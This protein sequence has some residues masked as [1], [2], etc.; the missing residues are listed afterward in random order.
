MLQNS[1]I[2][3]LN[4]VYRYCESKDNDLN[5][6]RTVIQ[7]LVTEVVRAEA[8]QVKG[9]K[10]SMYNYVSKNATRPVMECVY[11][12]N[13][14]KVASDGHI[15]VAIKEDYEPDFE[16]RKF[17]KDGE[18]VTDCRYPNWKSVIPRKDGWK[19]ATIDEQKF[20]EWIVER[21]AEHLAKVGKKSKWEPTWLVRINGTFFIMAEYFSLL[22][23][24]AK[25]IGT[26]VV[27]TSNDDKN[28]PCMVEGEN[29]L[30]ICMPVYAPD[31]DSIC[32]DM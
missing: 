25:R 31:E 4:E 8:Q 28:A 1:S 3:K 29:G 32:L 20:N 10:F 12:E 5:S 19:P 11:H 18:E 24:A 9:G 17:K 16:G 2:K 15:L 7:R 30:A 27:Y 6:F 23:A 21:R 22:A 26:D 13:G 14:Y